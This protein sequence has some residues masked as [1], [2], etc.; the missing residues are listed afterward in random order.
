MT[1]FRTPD[2]ICL[3]AQKSATTW[4]DGALRA[5][6]RFFLPRI[7]ELHYFS[8]IYNEDAR[9]YGPRHRAAQAFDQYN[10]LNPS[11]GPNENMTLS[12]LRHFSEED[13]DDAW[14]AQVFSSA[15]FDQVCA[16]ICPS[17]M[18]MPQAAVQHVLRLNPSVRLLLLVRDPVERCWSQMRMHIAQGIQSLEELAGPSSSETL[19]PFL[20]YSDYRGSISRWQRFAAPGQLKIMLHDEISADPSGC[21][22]QIVDF[23]GLTQSTTPAEARNITFKGEDMDMPP[24]LL[25]QLLSVLQPQYEFLSKLFPGAVEGWLAR[26]R[27]AL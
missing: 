12:Q 25:L 5:D 21:L 26:H 4:L 3:G 15:Q 20:F 23:V 27:S 13:V 18:N 14:Y 7:K 6:P 11:L 10:Y 8:Q 1:R 24:Q 9:L 22:A 2:F 19:W 17:Y 16:E